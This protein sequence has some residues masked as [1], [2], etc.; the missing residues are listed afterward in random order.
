VANITVKV[1]TAVLRETAGEVSSLIRTLQNDF[2][3]LQGCVR[4]TD[5]CWAGAAGDQYRRE[6]DAE[7]TVTAELLAAL[8]QYPKNLLSMAGIYEQTERVNAEKNGALPSNIL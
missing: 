8:R 5:R 7:K 3:E 4:H 6:F 2:D 1:E